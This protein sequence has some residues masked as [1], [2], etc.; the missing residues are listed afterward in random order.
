MNTPTPN[1]SEKNGPEAISYGG[2][3]GR[4]E[5]ERETKKNGVMLRV[6]AAV[7]VLV[8]VA[9]AVLGVVALAGGRFFRTDSPSSEDPAVLRVPTSQSSVS[10]ESLVERAREYT[11]TLTLELSDGSVLRKTGF[12][13]TSDGCV[14]TDGTV[15]QTHSVSRVTAYL[16]SFGAVNADYVGTDEAT[17]VGVVRLQGN[18]EYGPIL[19]GNSDYVKTGSEVFAVSAYEEEV[20]YGCVQ[21]GRIMTVV[22]KTALY[23]GETLEYEGPLFYTDFSFNSVCV[24]APLMDAEGKLV[25]LCTLGVTTPYRDA[26]AVIPASSL[27]AVFN[28]VLTRQS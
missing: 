5:Y 2:Y 8:V 15:F 13:V 27:S 20:Y 1:D 6:I 23:V 21:S 9:F 18:L 11:V 22:P 14:L 10:V 25:G 26:G 28:R 17:G 3:T 7:G 12:V 19:F 24:G 16:R 4:K